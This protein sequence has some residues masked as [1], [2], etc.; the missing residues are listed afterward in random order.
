MFLFVIF[1]SMGEYF[2]YCFNEATAKAL[3]SALNEKYTE[4]EN[5]FEYIDADLYLIN[6]ILGEIEHALEH[7][8]LFTKSPPKKDG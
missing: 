4:P 7:R 1:D 2:S 6:F 8:Q 3:V 5:R